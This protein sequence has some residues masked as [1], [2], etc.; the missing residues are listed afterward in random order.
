MAKYGM[1]AGAPPEAYA[2][3]VVA[4]HAFLMALPMW[5]VAGAM[6]LVGQSL[7]PDET[8]FRILMAEPLSRSVVFAAK[9]AALLLFGGLFVAGSH[10]GLLPLAALTLIGAAQDGLGRPGGG[11]V[12][13]VEP[14]RQPVRGARDRGH[15]RPAR[16]ARVAQPSAGVLGRGADRGDW[17]S[18]AGVAARDP[19]ARRG[20]CVRGERVVAGL[21]A[22]GMVR[23]TRTLAARRHD[24]RHAR[25]P[26]DG[27]DRRGGR[28]RRVRVRPPLPPLRSRDVPVSRARAV[29]WP[30]AVDRPVVPG[31]A[32]TGRGRAA[33]SRSR[34]SGAS[35]I[36]AWS[37]ACWRERAAWCSTAC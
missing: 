4:D 32:G 36:R 2:R 27:G 20:R 24:P 17:R 25:G 30:G 34:S 16:A 10:L 26:G 8:D 18:R 31:R 23:G 33:S 14:R 35:C 22:A 29:A 11:G 3:E 21:G 37:S 9:L 12:R 7:F 15:P 5:I 13:G 19:P 1:L 28:D 6:S